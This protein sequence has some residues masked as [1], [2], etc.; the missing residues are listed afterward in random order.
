MRLIDL[1][2]SCIAILTWHQANVAEVKVVTGSEA[3]VEAYAKEKPSFKEGMTWRLIGCLLLGCFC[4]TMNGFDGM[5]FG[6]LSANPI[7]LNFF[8]GA[9]N[10]A[11]Q[12]INA[13]MYQ[14]GGISALPA[15]GPCIDTWGRKVRFLGDALLRR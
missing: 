9:N 1:D 11:W 4:Q 8:H 3:Y 2:R 15:V 13:A 7:F 5:L 12:A 10:G 6:G 14:I